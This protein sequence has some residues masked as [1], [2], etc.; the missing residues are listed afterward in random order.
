MGT[1]YLDGSWRKLNTA[2]GAQRARARLNIK[3]FCKYVC[4]PRLII[5]IPTIK[6]LAVAAQRRLRLQ[7]CN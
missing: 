6:D 1:A 3:Q 4:I 5:A 2:K 7:P